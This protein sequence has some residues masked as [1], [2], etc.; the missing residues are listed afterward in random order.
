VVTAFG[1]GVVFV[2][3]IAAAVAGVRREETGL[4]SGVVN[5]SRTF[6]AALGIAALTTI[7]SAHDD[8]GG[9][10]GLAAGY[11]SAFRAGAV[12]AFTGAIVALA[13]LARR[14]PQRA[15]AAAEV[16]AAD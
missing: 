4:A 1:I 16:P 6:G 13:L 10:A 14:L 11:D 9:V 5:T 12:A 2:A 15:A 7:A 3:G 8:A